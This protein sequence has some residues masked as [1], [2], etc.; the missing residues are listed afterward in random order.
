MGVVADEFI[1]NENLHLEDKVLVT[2]LS[3]SVFCS[4]N[5]KTLACFVMTLNT[6]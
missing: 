4:T 5:G 6:L 1:T 3:V 2:I